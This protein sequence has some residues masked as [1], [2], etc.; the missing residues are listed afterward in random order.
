MIFMPT[1]SYG[2][3]YCDSLQLKL[4]KTKGFQAW[5]NQYDKNPNSQKTLLL[6]NRLIQSKLFKRTVSCKNKLASLYP[7]N[8][9]NN[10]VD[11]MI[12][13][14]VENKKQSK[15]L[16]KDK[17]AIKNCKLLRSKFKETK[18]IIKTTYDKINSSM[19]ESDVRKGYTKNHSRANRMLANSLDKTLDSVIPLKRSLQKLTEGSRACKIVFPNK[20]FEEMYDFLKLYQDKYRRLETRIE[21]KLRTA[22]I[23]D[24]H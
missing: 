5:S 24:I 7:K 1:F 9:N 18:K 12:K 16:R 14:A 20:G 13:S 22:R 19:D 17:T 21:N 4:T 23:Y 11:L 10:L 8:S 3:G 2:H 15:A 6:R